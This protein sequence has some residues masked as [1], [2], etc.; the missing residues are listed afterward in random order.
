MKV[1]I[2]KAINEQKQRIKIALEKI[3]RRNVILGKIRTALV[4]ID[5]V[6]KIITCHGQKPM[7]TLPSNPIY[8]AKMPEQLENNCKA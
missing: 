4:Q 3:E 5:N 8:M 6:C 7:Q 2:K 1:E